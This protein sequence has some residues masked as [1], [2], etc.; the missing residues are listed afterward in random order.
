MQASGYAFSIAATTGKNYIPFTIPLYIFRL[1][2]HISITRTY[3]CIQS[4]V[5]LKIILQYKILS[6]KSIT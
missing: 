6:R 1:G 3:F 4:E 5:F 2:I